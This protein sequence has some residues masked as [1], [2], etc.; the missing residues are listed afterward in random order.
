MRDAYK[1]IVAWKNDRKVKLSIERF[2]WVETFFI[3][4]YEQYAYV[5]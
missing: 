5:Q 2:A 3:G 1:A 4:L